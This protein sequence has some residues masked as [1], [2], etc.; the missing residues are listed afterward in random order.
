MTCRAFKGKLRQSEFPL[1]S[2]VMNG[3][4]CVKVDARNRSITEG[5][6]ANTESQSLAA[7]SRPPKHKTDKQ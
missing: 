6:A 5:L 7:Q 1:L 2:N 4:A 3:C